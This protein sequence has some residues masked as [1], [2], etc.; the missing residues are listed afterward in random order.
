[1]A[2]AP[3]PARSTGA[4]SAGGRARDPAKDMASRAGVSKVTIYSRYTDKESLFE[5]VVRDEMRGMDATFQQNVP[6]GGSLET[7]LNAFGIA[8]LGFLFRPDHIAM[9]RMLSL[10]FVDNP[11]LGRRFFDAGPGQCRARVAAMLADAAAA[12]DIRIDDPTAAAADVF[13]LW[14][15][16]YDLELKCGVRS[17]VSAATIKQ[18]VERGTALFLIAVAPR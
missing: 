13:S 12:G 4:R 2:T 16:F 15:G 17:A 11:E 3:P 5:H 10:A 1:M 14:K 18:R 6:V 9:D 7:R 8:L